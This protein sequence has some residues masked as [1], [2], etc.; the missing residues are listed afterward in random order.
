MNFSHAR[1]AM[2]SG[3]MLSADAETAADLE[4]AET[5][6]TWETTITGAD[7]VGSGCVRAS[8]VPKRDY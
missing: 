3:L 8:D 1:H 5:A 4:I 2:G 7:V 6:A